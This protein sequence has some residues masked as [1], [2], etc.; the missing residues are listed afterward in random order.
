MKPY[1]AFGAILLIILN[2]LL[3][4]I[5]RTLLDGDTWQ[6]DTFHTTAMFFEG[7]QGTDSLGAMLPAI[8]LL[9]QGL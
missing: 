4:L 6:A 7:R 5:D 3:L 8:H 9:E 1:I 2:G